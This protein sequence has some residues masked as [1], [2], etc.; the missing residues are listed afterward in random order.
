MGTLRDEVYENLDY[1][2]QLTEVVIAPQTELLASYP[3]RME[4]SFKDIMLMKANSW[5][6]GHKYHLD[7]TRVLQY[8]GGHRRD[9]HS[10]SEITN[11]FVFEISPGF[12]ID[13]KNGT[14][15]G[16]IAV[17]KVDGQIDD[18]K[19]LDLAIGRAIGELRS[20]T[21]NAKNLRMRT[22]TVLNTLEPGKGNEWV[23]KLQGRANNQAYSAITDQLRNVITENKWRVRDADVIRKMGI[24]INQYLADVDGGN[25][26]GLVNLM[27]LKIMIDKDLPIYSVDEVKSVKP[28]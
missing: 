13:M 28:A 1:L 14:M 5:S 11:N 4:L 21:W 27:K 2:S 19:L 15:V 10:Y 9:W 22:V 12:E 20:G 3:D 8:K 7:L 16:T 17:V 26:I 6:H 24:W 18:K 23:S 25:G